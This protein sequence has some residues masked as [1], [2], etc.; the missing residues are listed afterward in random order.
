MVASFVGSHACAVVLH[1]F[2]AGFWAFFA[3]FQAKFS[4]HFTQALNNQ[5][6]NNIKKKKKPAQNEWLI[7]LMN[8]AAIA[9]KFKNEQAIVDTVQAAPEH[10]FDFKNFHLLPD[11]FH[12]YRGRNVERTISL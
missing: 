3:N 4:S 2:C 6:R 8:S 1:R 7:D 5:V 12:A 11:D 9:I 10:D